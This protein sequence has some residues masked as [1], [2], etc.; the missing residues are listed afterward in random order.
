LL[1][2]FGVPGCLGV[3]S[4]LRNILTVEFIHLDEVLEHLTQVDQV[5]LASAFSNFLVDSD[6]QV[7]LLDDLWHHQLVDVLIG[8]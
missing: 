4:R 3:V 2:Q 1:H 6:Y 7:H 8:S 5:V